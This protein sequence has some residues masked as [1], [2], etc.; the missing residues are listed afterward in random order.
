MKAQKEFFIQVSPHT[1][2]ITLTVDYGIPKKARYNISTLA[3]TIKE[4]QQAETGTPSWMKS[5]QNTETNLIATAELDK[6]PPI[7]QVLSPSPVD[8]QVTR[9]DTYTSFIR[10]KVTDDEGVMTILVAGRKVGI[11]EDGTFASKVKL[12]IGRNDVLVQAEDINGN[13]SR[14]LSPLSGGVYH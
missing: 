1:E 2:T 13:V 14:R 8:G 9:V 10:G 4:V 3:R 5:W 11:K 7:V 6:N 12:A